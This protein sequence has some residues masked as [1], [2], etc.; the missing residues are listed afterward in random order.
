MRDF[1]FQ[2]TG[3]DKARSSSSKVSYLPVD[4]LMPL[5][6]KGLL[7]HKINGYWYKLFWW[8][9]QLFIRSKFNDFKLMLIKY[10]KQSLKSLGFFGI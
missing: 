3:I 6:K 2:Y 1:I 5:K 4:S 8:K 7:K 9:Q 10:D